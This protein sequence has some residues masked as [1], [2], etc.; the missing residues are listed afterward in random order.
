M[1]RKLTSFVAALALA[2][3]TLAPG[4]ADAQGYHR[5]HYNHGGYGGGRYY[6]RYYDHRGDAVAAGAVGL[7]LGLAIGS[8]ASAPR[9]GG[10][11]DRCGAPPPPPCGRCGPPPGYYNQGYQGQGYRG[12]DRSAYEDDYGVKNAVED[13]QCTRPERQ[14]DRYA[15]RY[16]TVD[17]PC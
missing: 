12:D 13:Y 10:C 8:I 14:Y 4:A 6:G 5:G 17:V 7:I 2:A 16:V 9:Q 3:A 15:G 11:Y 1:M